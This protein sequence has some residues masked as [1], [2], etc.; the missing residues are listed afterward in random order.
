AHI[1]E[2]WSRDGRTLL[3]SA[4]KDKSFSL[5][6][7]SLDTRKITP[8]GKMSESR[9][10]F[11]A[12]F[13]PDGRWVAY[14]LSRG[15]DAD[16]GVYVQPFPPTGASYQ[17]PKEYADFHPAWGTSSAELFY[18]PGQ[19]RLSMVSV[20]TQPTLTFGKPVTLPKPATRDR[21]NSD[22]RDYDVMPDGR[23]LSIVS[24][25][26]ERD[27]GSDDPPQILVVLNWLHQLTP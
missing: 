6:T 24:A 16:S 27:S 8:F 23:F 26:D 18:I 14:T 17:L 25:I 13:S 12:T 19:G 4:K 15:S 9:L 20:R 5:W 3:F 11:G 1:P 21:L 7:L 2:S 22:V 10:Q